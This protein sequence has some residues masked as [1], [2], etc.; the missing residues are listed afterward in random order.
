MTL[1][2]S[3]VLYGLGINTHKTSKLDKGGKYWK[4]KLKKSLFIVKTAIL[5][6]KL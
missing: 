6:T 1:C 2:V 3:G 5:Y 4:L